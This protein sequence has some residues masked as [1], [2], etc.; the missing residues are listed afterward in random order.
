MNRRQ[1]EEAAAALRVAFPD[2]VWSLYET[3]STTRLDVC[4]ELGGLRHVTVRDHHRGGYTADTLI[5]PD[6]EWALDVDD[7]GRGMG[8]DPVSA[9]RD[10]LT[11]H[12][13]RWESEE[14]H[15]AYVLTL[16]REREAYLVAQL[17]DCRAGIADL[18]S[19]G[20]GR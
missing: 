1:A 14:L 2:V 17:E 8:D 7:V 3:R 10:A 5:R 20:D 19:K 15:R 16:L 11:Q 18:E 9:M 13:G 6:N 12:D 4:G